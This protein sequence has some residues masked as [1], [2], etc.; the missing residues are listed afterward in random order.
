MTV[1]IALLNG[2]PVRAMS[3]ADIDQVQLIETGAYSYPWSRGNFL[4]SLAAHHD[5]R[6]LLDAQQAVIGYSIVMEG[7]D[8]EH[9]L[10]LT[11]ARH[12]QRCGWGRGLLD[13]VIQAARSRGAGSLW[14]EVRASNAA[15]LALYEQAGFARTGLRRAY[16]PARSGREDAVLMSLHLAPAEPE[17]H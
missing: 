8:E 14:L 6:V 9:L 13:V 4:D 2:L 16:Y 12:L 10:N 15:A 17:S 3:Q 11:V 1:P 7:V 5:A